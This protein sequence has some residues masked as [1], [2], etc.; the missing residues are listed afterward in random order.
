MYE[1]KN[2][3]FADHLGAPCE[4][5]NNRFTNSHTKYNLTIIATL[6]DKSHIVRRTHY[7]Y[8]PQYNKFKAG[9]GLLAVLMD[10]QA[11]AYDYKDF[12]TEYGYTNDD[13]RARRVY[14]SCVSAYKFF[15][16]LGLNEYE[17]ND[18]VQ[19]LDK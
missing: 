14:N 1:Y 7:Q 18:F 19:Q 12:C 4:N 16:K 17:I 8:A 5:Q 10:A 13:P 3:K 2:I 6:P 9:D 15:E 11:G